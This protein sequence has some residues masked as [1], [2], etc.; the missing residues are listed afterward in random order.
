LR[1]AGMRAWLVSV[2][3]SAICGSVLRGA[4]Y[5]GMRV[6]LVNN[7]ALLRFEL[8]SARAHL[9]IA[10]TVSGGCVSSISPRMQGVAAGLVPFGSRI[11]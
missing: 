5:A 8:F 4:P 1:G 11:H 10:L 2:A 6:W 9:D 3:G 7:M